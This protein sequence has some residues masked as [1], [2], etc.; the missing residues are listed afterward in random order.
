MT[1]KLARADWVSTAVHSQILGRPHRNG[2]YL[3]HA[4]EVSKGVIRGDK[5]YSDTTIRPGV[6]PPLHLNQEA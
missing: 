3:G 1:A 5:K 6:T 2:Q 4:K